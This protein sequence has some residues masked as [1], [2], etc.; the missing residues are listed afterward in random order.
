[1]R[2]LTQFSTFLSTLRAGT[3]GALA[4]AAVLSCSEPG[5]TSV[6]P[7]PDGVIRVKVGSVEVV[8]PDSVKQ[9]L[10]AQEAQG[11]ANS[12]VP[13]SMAASY[14]SPMS[15]AASLAAASSCG[16]LGTTPGY[17][18]SKPDNF[19]PEDIPNI[20]PYPLTDD[21]WIPDSYVS[22]GFDFNFYGNTYNKVNVYS[23][24]FLL[25]G[26]APPRSASGFAPGGRIPSTANPKNI[27]AFAWT[28]WSPQLVQD[29]IR[30]ETRG[31]APN[32][33][34]V[35]QFN[36]VPEYYSASRLGAIVP[37]A[38]R[39]MTQVVLYEGSNNIT[40]YTNSMTIT[41]SG[42]F[43]TQGIEDLSGT[44][45][46]ADSVW[47][48]TLG[49]PIP[50]VHYVFNLSNDVVQFSPIS[51]KDVVPPTI[52][53]PANISTGNDPGLASALVAVGSPVANDDC[54]QVNI[55]SV[56]SDGK[57]I[58]AP[59]PVGVTTITWTATDAEGNSASATQT[60]TVLDIEPPVFA[61]DRES[62][63]EV[64]AT[65]PSG[66]AVTFSL[67]VTDNVGVTSVSCD[68][69]SGSVFPVGSTP[70]TC[71]ARDAAGNS[72]SISFSVSVVGAHQQIGNLMEKMGDLGLPN[73]T[74]QP[75][76]NQLRLA[77]TQTADGGSACTKV[78]DFLSMV[79]KK[80]SN[81]SSEEVAA[82]TADGTRIMDVMG[83]APPPR[84]S[85][86]TT[87]FNR[88]VR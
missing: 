28:D 85:I 86:W 3:I 23:N 79:Q 73:G 20:A 41:N 12:V 51:S 27:L 47:N 14:L 55:S 18:K 58:D 62:V 36:N 64:N 5:T 76:I 42:H 66:A 87:G 67:R 80:S 49:R 25:F 29:G 77:Y 82:L 21:G 24:G 17:T 71:T 15:S 59:Y 68:P 69:E 34:F 30:W 38:G 56:R 32:R 22:I 26:P 16:S 46:L 78:G 75:L 48:A 61:P 45:W 52:T 35:L 11:S 33:R 44:Q 10:A 53:A 19:R 70:V 40:I 84:A 39:V 9:A 57:L 65:S 88:I 74:L 54:S 43:V 60:V 8:V 6:A 81:L 4:L 37:Q 83:C 1:M 63:M 50:R 72:A 31:A 13:I 7:T 2:R